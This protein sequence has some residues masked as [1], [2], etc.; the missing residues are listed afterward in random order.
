MTP[1]R[2]R[3]LY[4]AY[5]LLPVTEACCGGAEQAMLLLESQMKLRGHRTVVAAC[6][7]SRVS[8]ELFTTGDSPA[9]PDAFQVRDAEH[10][11]RILAF[12]R[13]EQ[14]R[15]GFDLIHDHGGSFWKYADRL[16]I[17]VLATLHLPRDFYPANSF[18][19]LPANLTINCVSTSQ[20]QT[21]RDLGQLAGVVRNGINVDRFPFSAKKSNYLLWLGRICN[22][23]GLHI[24]LDIADWLA[25]PII[26][27]GQVYPFSYHQDYF[28]Q[29]IVP[30][31][32]NM[33]DRARLM[34]GISLSE[35]LTLLRDARAVLIPSLA[36]E[37]SSLI[38]MEAMASGTPAV[39][40]RRGALPEVV[41]DGATGFIVDSAEEMA[42]AI[43]RIAE[44]DARACRRHVE[45][46][47]AATRMAAEYEQLYR[48]IISL[49]A[50]RAVASDAL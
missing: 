24:A 16:E 18:D 47:F 43:A 34:T 4:V 28:Q 7:G 12:L 33:G 6:S 22:E 46:H 49:S 39:A 38:A 15:Q 50:T 27:A 42:E 26:A 11:Q 17:P 9:E 2:L 23:K 25:I 41:A 35:K 20:A 19:D 1:D 45:Q 29:Q 36:N 32:R 5:S 3:I 30:R 21:F 44:I 40:F 37:T 8:G 31:L 14:Q 13:K 48:Q 10:V